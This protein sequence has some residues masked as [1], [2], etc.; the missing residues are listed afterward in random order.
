MAVNVVKLK[1]G[2]SARKWERF[3]A[4]QMSIKEKTHLFE[5]KTRIFDQPGAGKGYRR[6]EEGSRRV[7]LAKNG[8]FG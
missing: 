2:E 7:K 1:L 8:R 4:R 3:G 5:I 6:R